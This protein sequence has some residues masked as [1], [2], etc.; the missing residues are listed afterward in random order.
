MPTPS[1]TKADPPVCNTAPPIGAIDN[2]P[3]LVVTTV[4][5]SQ[6]TDS[7]INERN[8]E[9]TDMTSIQ[10]MGAV[11]VLLIVLLVVMTS[12]YMYICWNMKKSGRLRTISK[13]MTR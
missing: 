8:M 1:L 9:C 13:Q 6:H 3:Q 4:L 12:G 2:S 10:A 5:C 11:M 7:D